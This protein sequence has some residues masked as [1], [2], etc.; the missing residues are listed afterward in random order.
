MALSSMELARR[1]RE[2]GLL[3]KEAAEDVLRI[4][5]RLFREAMAKTA[6]GLF[7]RLRQAAGEVA[8]KATAKGSS[9]IDDMKSQLGFA[10]MTGPKNPVHAPGSVAMGPGGELADISGTVIKDLPKQPKKW[11]EYAGDLGKLLALGAGLQGAGMAVTGLMR[12]SRDKDVRKD[13]EKSYKEMFNETPT[14]SN[15]DPQKVTRHF[16]VLARYAPSLAADPTVAGA[17][18]KGTVQMGHIDATAV[19]RLGAT[20][21]LI[22][23]HHEGRALFQPGHFHTGVALARA[24]MG[25]G[26]SGGG[27]G[28]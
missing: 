11:G 7:G 3:S 2:K 19:E 15:L 23:R 26:S 12:H 8:G 18:V 4:R 10:G 17:W 1:C 28:G 6:A 9:F 24:A 20:Q 16:D 22:D 27:G 14:L 13:I 21:A 25:G 5:Q